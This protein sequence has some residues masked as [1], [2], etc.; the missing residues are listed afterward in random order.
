[1]EGYLTIA[2]FAKQANIT[3]QAVY[4]RIEKELLPFVK[5]I[6]NILTLAP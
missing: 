5:I 1:M 6:K 3:R 2:E 4:Q